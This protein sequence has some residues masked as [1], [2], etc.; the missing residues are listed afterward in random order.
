MRRIEPS[1]CM[2]SIFNNHNKDWTAFIHSIIH[3][4]T[5]LSLYL[6][7]KIRRK[8][9][10]SMGAVSGQADRQASHFTIIN[11]DPNTRSFIHSSLSY[12]L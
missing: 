5:F 4:G 3:L 8:W 1:I 12:L 11:T 10:V 6:N 9:C 2:A 7:L